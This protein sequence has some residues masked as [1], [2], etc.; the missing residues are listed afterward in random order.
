MAPMR[1]LKEGA[2]LMEGGEVV[3]M[4]AGYIALQVENRSVRFLQEIS[5]AD[6]MRE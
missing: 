4:D 2:D 3:V 6:F 5:P 1:L